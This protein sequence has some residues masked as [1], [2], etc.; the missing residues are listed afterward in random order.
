[1]L[2]AM[3]AKKTSDDSL[4]RRPRQARA[5]E[6]FERILDTAE[7]VFAEVGYESATTNL[8]AMRAQT[9][10]GSLYEFFPNKDALASSLAE[11]YVERI[12]TLYSK[13]VVDEPATS[14]QVLVQHIIAA[15]DAFYRDNPGAVPLLNGRLTSQD[16]MEAGER[17]QRAFVSG[18]EAIVRIRRPDVPKATAHLRAVA[19]AEITRSLLMIADQVPL[20]QRK[21]VVRELE[22]A[23]VGY[24]SY[25]DPLSDDEWI[26]LLRRREELIHAT[27]PKND[28]R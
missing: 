28:L 24:V 10:I 14:T 20:S 27:P 12:G 7:Q 17:L 8:I 23:I 5:L 13:H 21:A 22:L 18:I 19:I 6:R 4:R 16:L 3:P 26:A 11:R 15:I 1:M 9:S 25:A 2:S